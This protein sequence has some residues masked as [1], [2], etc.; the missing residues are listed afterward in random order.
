MN[1]NS[2]IDGGHRAMLS[3]MAVKSHE[4]SQ[5]L[6]T[7]LKLTSEAVIISKTYLAVCPLPYIKKKVNKIS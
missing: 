1:K 7:H 2:T 5:I 3:A 4:D 6:Q